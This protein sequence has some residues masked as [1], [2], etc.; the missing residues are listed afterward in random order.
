MDPGQVENASN[1]ADEVIVRHRPSDSVNKSAD[2][3]VPS[4]PALADARIS[5]GRNHCSQKPA[6]DFCNK[7][8]QELIE[9]GQEISPLA[10]GARTNDDAARAMR[11]LVR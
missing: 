5:A 4:S 7:I 11:A 1:R 10:R 6:T 3:V 2:P 9:L 8:S